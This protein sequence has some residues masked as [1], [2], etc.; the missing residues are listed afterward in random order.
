LCVWERFKNLKAIDLT[1]THTRAHT[2]T[3]TQTRLHTCNSR[4]GASYLKDVPNMK[5][6]RLP[7]PPQNLSWVHAAVWKVRACIEIRALIESSLHPLV[8]L[9]HTHTHTHTNT[10]THTHVN[11][12][13]Y[14]NEIP[15]EIQNFR[16]CKISF[17]STAESCTLNPALSPNI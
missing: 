5:L 10:H 16:E 15:Y 17:R 7:G 12:H 1:H 8:C 6:R 14:T 13:T 11:I 2:H 3:R 9:R 4:K